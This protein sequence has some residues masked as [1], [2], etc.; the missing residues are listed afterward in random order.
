M[1]QCWYLQDNDLAVVGDSTSV[2]HL[3]WV[4]SSSQN[5]QMTGRTHFFVGLSFASLAI[6][7]AGSGRSFLRAC[8]I[9]LKARLKSLTLFRFIEGQYNTIQCNAIQYSAVQYNTEPK[10]PNTRFNNW[11]DCHPSNS[12]DGCRLGIRWLIESPLYEYKCILPLQHNCR[13]CS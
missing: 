3:S 4:T 6:R 5:F 11:Q 10:V 12:S 7:I 13:F 1:Y 8:D 2:T 9:G